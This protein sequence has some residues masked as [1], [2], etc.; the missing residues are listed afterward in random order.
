MT[1]F[2]FSKEKKCDLSI[3]SVC[4]TYNKCQFSSYHYCLVPYDF[5][6]VYLH[7]ILS[8]S[9]CGCIPYT[10][11][12]YFVQSFVNDMQD[13]VCTMCTCLSGCHGPDWLRCYCLQIHEHGGPMP[14]ECCY[15]LQLRVPLLYITCS[16]LFLFC[17]LYFVVRFERWNGGLS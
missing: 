11:C 6:I 17:D 1:H 14:C 8:E 7:S 9:V 15:G 10:Y 3:A 5:Y 13:S 4:M 2:L 16:L 12:I